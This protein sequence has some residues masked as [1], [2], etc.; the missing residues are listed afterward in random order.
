MQQMEV[1][2][3]VAAHSGFG[4]TR[5]QAEAV[6]HGAANVPGVAAHLLDVA[7]LSEDDWATLDRADAIIFGSPTYMGSPSRAGAGG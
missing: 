7:A 3:A 6:A 4:H 5:R 2:I 1:H